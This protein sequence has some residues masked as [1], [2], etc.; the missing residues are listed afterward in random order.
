M[1]ENQKRAS[2]LHDDVYGVIINNSVEGILAVNT[3]G[4]ILLANKSCC[5]LFGYSN[6]QLIGMKIEELI[7]MRFKKD[8]IKLRHEYSKSPSP[9]RMGQG[10][11]LVAIKSDKTEFPIEVSLNHTQYEGK[12]I[13]MAFI[14]DITKR[15]KTDEALKK[16]EEK[17]LKYASELESQVQERTK[18]LADAF[19]EL[20]KSNTQLEVEI[21]IRKKAENETRNALEHERELNELKSR[22]VSMASHEFRTPLSTILSSASLIDRY[23][24]ESEQN[25]RTNHVGKIKSAIN[26][27]TG[28]LDDFLSLSKLEEGKIEI[29]KT[30][31]VVADMTHEIVEEM[32]SIA[33][34]GQRIIF[35]NNGVNKDIMSDE[36]IFKN[37][38]I[39]LISNAIKYSQPETEINVSLNQ[40]DSA[41]EISI[42]DHG[43]GIPMDEQ[44]RLFERF[45]RAKNA[46]NIHGTGLGLNIVKKY[47]EMLGGDISFVSKLNEGSTFTVKIPL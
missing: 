36:K 7:P 43:M 17:L 5:Q 2:K 23:T 37:I 11:D 46:T 32:R 27:L 38:L 47:V 42:Q 18:K 44:K 8:H 20:K 13:V 15:K 3:V 1:K 41:I 31:L 4:V 9:R 22:F 25:K 28:I 39:N 26:N 45:F 12:N 40:K 34:H 21:K 29:N 33:K 30:N 14:I 6:D 19:G 16:S 10:R 24:Q 35:S